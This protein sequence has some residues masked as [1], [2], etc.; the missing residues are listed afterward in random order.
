MRGETESFEAREGERAR[1]GS[2]KAVEIV[3][4]SSVDDVESLLVSLHSFFEAA[5]A[6]AAC[7]KIDGRDRSSRCRNERACARER[8]AKAQEERKK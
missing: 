1:E 6:E 4:L 8:E 3:D 5:A 7:E 2:S